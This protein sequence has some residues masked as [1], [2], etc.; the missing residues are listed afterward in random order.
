MFRGGRSRRGFS[1]LLLDLAYS[2]AECAFADQLVRL[3]RPM[4]DQRPGFRITMPTGVQAGIGWAVALVMAVGWSRH[5]VIV[6]Q[7]RRDFFRVRYGCR[8]A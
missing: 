1:V 2:F 4:Y 5:D 7:I 3:P 8:S 6:R